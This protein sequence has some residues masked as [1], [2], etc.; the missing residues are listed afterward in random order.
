MTENDQFAGCRVIPE[1]IEHGYEED[2]QNEGNLSNSSIKAV[3]VMV[4]LYQSL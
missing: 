1:D 2:E 3:N 4:I